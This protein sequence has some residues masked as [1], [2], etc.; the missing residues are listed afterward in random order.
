MFLNHTLFSINSYQP[1]EELAVEM[2]D[3]NGLLKNFG[4][5]LLFVSNTV[6][7]QSKKCSCV[8]QS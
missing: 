7:L 2:K 8:C 4:G 3:F 5:V 1:F 6:D